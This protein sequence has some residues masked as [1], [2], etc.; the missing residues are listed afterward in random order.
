MGLIDLNQIML[1]SRSDPFNYRIRLVDPVT[2]QT[3]SFQVGLGG[4]LG[5][6]L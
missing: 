4:P 5:I 1:K 3:P 2:T 6:Y